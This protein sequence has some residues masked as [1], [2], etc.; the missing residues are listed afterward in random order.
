MNYP[1]EGHGGN[2]AG[3]GNGLA[4]G[5][6]A[7]DDGVSDQT[8]HDVPANDGPGLGGRGRGQAKQQN[9]DRSEGRA[10]TRQTPGC[11]D[12]V[13][14]DVEGSK[15][16]ARADSGNDGVHGEQLI[17]FCVLVTDGWMDGWM[18]G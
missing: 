10:E 12:P 6:P 3:Y 2:R 1:E 4:V 5:D 16:D 13:V 17:R 14:N 8:R 18:D 7:F 11:E 9:G 15:A